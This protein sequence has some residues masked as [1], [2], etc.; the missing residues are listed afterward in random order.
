MKPISFIVVI[1]AAAFAAGCQHGKPSGSASAE[2]KGT[3][4]E[5]KAFVAKTDADLKRLWVRS[6]TAEW[7]KSTYITDDTERAAAWANEEVMAY[8]AKAIKESVRYVGVPGLDP[9]SQR[10]LQLLRVSSTLPAP[11]DA[12]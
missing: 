6:S 2:G 4:E 5:A 8:V 11:D 1:L 12:A 9:D 3:P 7:I 10:M